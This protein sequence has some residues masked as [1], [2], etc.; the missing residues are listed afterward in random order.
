MFGDA[1][2]F[3]RMDGVAMGVGEERMFEEMTNQDEKEKKGI[4]RPSTG[5]GAG[6]GVGP[7]TWDGDEE[8]ELFFDGP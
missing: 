6:P 8:M 5:T 4:E 2:A 3:G 1:T 7:G